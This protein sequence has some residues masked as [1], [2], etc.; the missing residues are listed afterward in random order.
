MKVIQISDCH[1]YAESQRC[2]YNDINPYL[3]LSNVLQKAVQQKPDVILFTGDLSGDASEQSYQHFLALI[4]RYVGDTTWWYIPGNHDC[5]NTMFQTFGDH[6]LC[7]ASPFL[8]GN[9][10]IHGL[11]SHHVGTLGYVSGSSV[12]RLEKRIQ[13]EAQHFHLIAVHHHPILTQSWMDKHEWLN[14]DEFMAFIDRAKC[15]R[16][17][18]YGHIHTDSLHQVGETT[19]Y[20]CPSSCWQWEMQP[21]FAF[22]QELPGFRTILLGADGGISSTVTRV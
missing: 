16:A 3:S 5:P 13:S 7:E 22:S 1:L 10:Q 20:S 19:F 21:T 4:K 18:I 17:V 6:V 9:W 15:V 12:D 14:R 8:L 2:G 11:N